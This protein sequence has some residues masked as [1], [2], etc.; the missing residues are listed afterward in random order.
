MSAK[1]QFTRKASRAEALARRRI[2]EKYLELADAIAGDSG[3]GINVCV[4]NAV[5]AGIAAG[6]AICIVAHGVYAAGPDHAMAAALLTRIDRSLG[7]RLQDLVT[8]KSASH[9]GRTLLTEDGRRRALRAARILVEHARIRTD[10][11]P[12]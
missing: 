4:G 2:A 9:Y 6:D 7:G 12:G 10:F 8:M 11:D 5:L 3:V 1:E